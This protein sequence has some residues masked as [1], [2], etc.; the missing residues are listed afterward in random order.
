VAQPV[1]GASR[2]LVSRHSGISI[3]GGSRETHKNTTRQ[4]IMTPDRLIDWSIT[5]VI[6]VGFLSMTG[7]QDR[8]AKLFGSKYSKK[9][10]EEKVTALESRIEKLE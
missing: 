2:R 10:L 6:C 1:A 3:L 4:K 7:I 5:I 8:V 9:E